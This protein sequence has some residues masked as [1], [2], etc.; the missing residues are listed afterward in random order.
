MI[1]GLKIFKSF[2]MFGT[3]NLHREAAT[4]LNIQITII[5]QIEILKYTK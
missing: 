2:P 4:K 3:S 1:V 5:S